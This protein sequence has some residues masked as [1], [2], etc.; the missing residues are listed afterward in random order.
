MLNAKTMPNIF[1]AEAVACIVYFLNHVSYK[2]VQ[3]MAP[4]EA[5]SGHKPCISHL[6]VFGSVACSLVPNEIRRKLD[7]QLEKCAFVGYSEKS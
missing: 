1:W 7:Y 5:W 3:D 4:Q 2:S 6:R